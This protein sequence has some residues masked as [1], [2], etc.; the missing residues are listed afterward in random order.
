M[1]K[2]LPA[3]ISDQSTDNFPPPTRTTSAALELIFSTAERI[4]RLGIAMAVRLSRFLYDPTVSLAE[5]ALFAI[6]LSTSVPN[7][8]S[9]HD[10]FKMH[11]LL[12]FHLSN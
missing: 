5:P 6:R 7:A 9:P 4:S 12:A 11:F 1:T 10:V 2:L 3:I 8:C